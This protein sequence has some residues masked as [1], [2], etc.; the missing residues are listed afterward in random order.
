MP[1][2]LSAKDLGYGVEHRIRQFT[3][4]D[5]KDTEEIME[6]GISI[7]IKVKEKEHDK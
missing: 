7:D 1:S 5:L 3:N 2:I 4:I 6:I